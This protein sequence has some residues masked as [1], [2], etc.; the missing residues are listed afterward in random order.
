MNDAGLLEALPVTP[1]VAHAARPPAAAGHS[2]GS[3]LAIGLGWIWRLVIGPVLCTNYFLAVAV[4]GWMTRHMQ[5]LAIRCWW[6]QSP[7]QKLGTFDAFCDSLGPDAPTARPRWFWRERVRA[8]VTRRHPNGQ[9]PGAGRLIWRGLGVPI[10]SFYRNVLIGVQMIAGSFLIAGWANMLMTFSW[11][12]GWYNSFHKG[13]EISYLG[14]LTGLGGVFLFVAAMFYLPMAQ[15]HF[16]LTGQL[17]SFVEVSFI[18]KLVRTRLLAYTGVAAVIGIA[19]IPLEILMIMPQYLPQLNPALESISDAQYAQILRQYYFWAAMVFFVAFFVCRHLMARVYASA[20]LTALRRG[21]V[22]RSELNRVLGRWIDRLQ[23]DVTPTLAP[24]GFG[25]A[26]AGGGSW[27]GRRV[28]F[29]ALFFIWFAVISAAYVREFL[30]Y[31]PFTGFMNHPMVYLP[32]PG[33]V[34]GHLTD[35]TD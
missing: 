4:V 35:A 22:T 25:A 9:S 15:A 16:A 2:F 18:W 28:L 13:Y 27:I 5:G 31:H 11:Q 6:K 19:C 21:V 7:L 1:A 26:V 29:T 14:P 32:C 20:V 23:L 34:P 24:V 30:N 33:V 10:H 17:R 8:S 12:F 3:T